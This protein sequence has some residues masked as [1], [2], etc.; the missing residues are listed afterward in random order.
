MEHIAGC[1]HDCTADEVN[2]RMH[3]HVLDKSLTHTERNMWGLF[4][5]CLKEGTI[6]NTL[7]EQE[8]LT[9]KGTYALGNTEGI[10]VY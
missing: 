9:K 4:S 1:Y 8:I 7:S 3:L 10:I 5:R 6:G 2:L